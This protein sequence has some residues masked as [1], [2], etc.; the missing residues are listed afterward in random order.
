MLLMSKIP[1]KLQE[2]IDARKRYRLSDAHIQMA[3]ELGL[4]PS[5]LEKLTP[6]KDQKW[7]VPLADFIEHLYEKRFKR[8]APPEVIT[9]EKLAEHQARKKQRKDKTDD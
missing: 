9:I 2:W 5:S 7:K 6:N 3:R 1:Q 4:K 8:S